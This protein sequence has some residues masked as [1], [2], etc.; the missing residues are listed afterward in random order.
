MELGPIGMTPWNVP[1]KA[2]LSEY[3]FPPFE[4][5]TRLL[6]NDGVSRDFEAEGGLRY[7]H[8]RDGDTDIYFVA[9]PDTNWIGAACAFRVSGKVPEIWQPL[10]GEIKRQ[11]LYEQRD[12]RTLLPLWLEPAGSGVVVFS[13][14]NG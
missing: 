4:M 14:L 9:N 5:I 13:Q 2:A 3:S 6:A 10:T 12:G 7:I 1:G 8:R 11:A